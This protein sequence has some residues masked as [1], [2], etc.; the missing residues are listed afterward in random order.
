MKASRMAYLQA[1][2]QA[3]H[4]DRPDD[5]LWRQ[6]ESCVELAAYLDAARATALRPW[7]QQ[8]A[9]DATV[10]EIELALRGDWRRYTLAVARWA[11][12]PWRPAV[13]WMG[14]L[15]DLPH[16]THLARNERPQ[17]WMLSDPVLSPLALEDPE[18]RV[19]AL[20]DSEYSSLFERIVSGALPVAAH[21]RLR[22]L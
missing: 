20:A 16:L 15:P 12:L 11:P 22:R 1:R 5:D 13:G 7:V 19:R 9:A 14:S 17:S 6:L 2:L 8:L 3:R 18:L 21:W 4:G 10:H